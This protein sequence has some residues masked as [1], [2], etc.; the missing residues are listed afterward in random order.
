MVL[1]VIGYHIRLPIVLDRVREK[2]STGVKVN[3]V[4]E[5]SLHSSGLPLKT[6][7]AVASL[8]FFA[9]SI[10]GDVGF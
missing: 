5:I 3:W 9:F 1:L 8:F 7:V 2:F 10:S 6:L 4:Y